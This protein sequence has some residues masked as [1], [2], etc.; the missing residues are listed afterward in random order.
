MP[1]GEIA[2]EALGGVFRFVAHIVFE[3][4]VEWLLRGTGAL[5]LRLSRPRH[6]PGET[7]AIVT[8]LLFWIAMV[9]FGFWLY[10]QASP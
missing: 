10:R 8:G 9:A 6:E 3:I 2:G 7:A 4:V 1:L 5:I